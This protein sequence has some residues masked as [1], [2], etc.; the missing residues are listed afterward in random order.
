MF[1]ANI[2]NNRSLVAISNR[3]RRVVASPSIPAR[4]SRVRADGTRLDLTGVVTENGDRFITA[5]AGRLTG[6]LVERFVRTR[7]RNFD[8]KSA[9]IPDTAPHVI[10]RSFEMRVVGVGLRL[11]CLRP[12]SSESDSLEQAGGSCRRREPSVGLAHARN[13][14]DISGD[15]SVGQAIDYRQASLLILRTHRHRI[16]R[17][18]LEA[19]TAAK[20][21]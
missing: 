6:E 1:D 18:G 8:E 19:S 5:V 4:D 3:N 17:S 11:G 21:S 16:A 9:E 14:R 20:I 13:C 15:T 7:Q 12:Y 10:E 2:L